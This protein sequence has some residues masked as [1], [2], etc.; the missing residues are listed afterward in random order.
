MSSLMNR[1]VKYREGN[2]SIEG[3][4]PKPI[5][6]STFCPACET[7]KKPGSSHPKCSPILKQMRAEGKI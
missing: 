5:V 3:K 2:Y 1:W 4:N 6:F 7:K